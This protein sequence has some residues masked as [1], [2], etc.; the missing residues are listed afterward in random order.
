MDYYPPHYTP[1]TYQFVCDCKKM[2]NFGIPCEHIVHVMVYLGIAEMPTSL[3]LKRWAK[4][5]QVVV[6][7]TC[8]D[9]DISYLPEHFR[10]Q[11]DMLKD[12]NDV[13]FNNEDWNINLLVNSVSGVN[14]DTIYC[15]Y[16]A[17]Y[18]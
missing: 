10:D 16:N 18:G 1:P 12:G 11:I 5:A 14:A 17:I 4:L 13:N 6:K 7:G 9:D 2:E 3:V 8:D 15:H